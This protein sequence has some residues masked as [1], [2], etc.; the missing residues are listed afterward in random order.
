LINQQKLSYSITIKRQ[1]HDG[2]ETQESSL[3]GKTARGKDK[4]RVG[5][6]SHDALTQTRT[7]TNFLSVHNNEND[8]I[9]W[10][11]KKWKCIN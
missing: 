7:E 4:Q 5:T 10:G 1:I 3:T 2:L 11:N 6:G 8:Q 9:D